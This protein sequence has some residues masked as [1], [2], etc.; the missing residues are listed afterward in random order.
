MKQAL[1]NSVDKR[2]LRLLVLASIAIL[3]I[4]SDLQAQNAIIGS[5]F[6]TG[7][8]VANITYP[9]SASA[10]TSRIATFAS[11][12]TGL[13]YFRL[14]RGWTGSGCFDGNNTEYGPSSNTDTQ[15]SS[16]GTVPSTG[17]SSGS[18]AWFVNDNGGTGRNYIIKTFSPCNSIRWTMFYVQGA[19][20]TISSV[21]RDKSTIYP[22]QTIT[23]TAGMSAALSTGQ[24]VYC[25]YT[26]DNYA[27]STVAQM[28]L[29][30]G[31]NY[32]V[33]TPAFV[34][35]A[36]L[37][38]YCFTS[39]SGL[40]IS[41]SDADFFTINLN[42]NGGSN[43][44]TTVASAWVT[45]GAGSSNT[46][47]TWAGGVVPIT[48]QPVQIS[49]A[50]TLNADMTVSGL[51]I[52]GGG[53][54][55][56][57]SNTININAGGALVN[58][59]TFNPG[60]G[61]VNFVGA[62][63]V[64]GSAGCT[65]N[66]LTLNTGQLTL[67]TAPTVNGTFTINSGNLDNAAN[68]I[69]YGASST[70]LY[71]AA[72]GYTIFKEWNATADGAAGSG[73]P[74]N[75]SVANGGTL[76]MPSSLESR[77][78]AGSLTLCATC[79]LTF[80]SAGDLILRGS[81]TNNHT[82]SNVNFGSG[83]GRAVFFTVPSGT[84][85]ISKASG[86]QTFPFLIFNNAGTVNIASPVEVTATT[87][88]PLQIN[89][90]GPI[91][92]S[93][94]LTL[95]GDNG[96]IQAN[97]TSEIS[98][99]STQSIFLTGNKTIPSSNTGTLSIG[100]N[101]VLSVANT[102]TLTQADNLSILSGGTLT[103]TGTLSSS[104]T[105]NLAS[106]STTNANGTVAL[107]T[108]SS[109]T[110]AGRITFGS[111]SLLRYDN[112]LTIGNEWLATTDGAAGSGRPADVSVENSGT[113]TMPTSL[114][115][116]AMAGS[117]TICATCS[118][119]FQ[120]SGGLILRGSWINNHAGSNVN[121]GSSRPVTFT[122]PSGTATI[123]KASGTQTF[124]ILILNNT[125][126]VNIACPV[127][128]STAVVPLQIN[129]SG[130]ITLGNSLTLINDGGNIQVNGTSEISASSPQTIFING[131]KIIPSTNTGTL[132]I[133][134]NVTLAI[135]STKS[136]TQGDI[137]SIM[138][139]ATLSVMGTMSLTSFSLTTINGTVAL[140]TGASISGLGNFTYGSSSILRYDNSL[141]V[142]N[143]WT[144]TS[145]T[146]AGL[147]LPATV[148]IAAGATLTVNGST[149]VA[150]LLSIN[151]TGALTFSSGHGINLYTGWTN[152]HATGS[153]ITYFSDANRITFVGTTAAINS[154]ASTATFRELA[155]NTTGQVTT[156]AN[157]VLT[158]TTTPLSIVNTG[159]LNLS[160]FSITF[161]GT[162]GDLVA[163][164]SGAITSS[165]GTSTITI[166][167][168]KS[169]PASNT[170]TL[171]FGTGTAP[172]ISTGVTL[173]QNDNISLVSGVTLVVTG[174]LASNA[175]TFTINSG[176]AT[177]V[178]GAL[179]MGGGVFVGTPTY[180][181]AAT[182]TYTATA[183]VSD[184]WTATSGTAAGLGL[185]ATVNISGGTATLAAATR[186]TGAFTIASA[187]LVTF[188][189][190]SNLDLYGSFNNQK[191]TA[192]S[193]TTFNGN[194]TIRFVG[195]S[196]TISVAGGPSGTQQFPVLA[197]N[198]TGKVT[199]N[200]N[201]N[202]TG[203]STNAFLLASTGTV[204]IGSYT[205]SL[206]GASPRIG[207]TGS[208]S[209][210]A[211]SGQ[212]PIFS[213][214][215]SDGNAELPSSNTAT[216]TLPS[217]F[218]L[219]VA[220]GTLTVNAAMTSLT[221]SAINV[222]G[223]LVVGS[224]GTVTVNSGSTMTVNGAGTLDARA[225]SY[226]LAGSLSNSG[227][228][229][230]N[231]SNFAVT[232][233][234][235]YSHLRNGGALPQPTT[236]TSGS[237]VN[238]NGVTST[239]PTNLNQ[240]F[241]RL[242]WEC[243]GQSV[244]LEL[245]SN[246]PANSTADFRVTNTNNSYLGLGAS[247][248]YTAVTVSGKFAL[249]L[250]G[251]ATNVTLTTPTLGFVNATNNK[252]QLALGLNPSSTNAVLS[253]GTIQFNTSQAT[254][255]AAL[256]GHV[257]L[258]GGYGTEQ[259][260]VTSSFQQTGAGIGDLYCASPSANTQ[261]RLN[262]SNGSISNVNPGFVNFGGKVVIPVSSVYTFAS[263]M[264]GAC[265][266]EVNG[267]TTFNIASRVL[268][269]TGSFTLASGATLV[270]PSAAGLAA[271]GATGPIR[272]TGTRSYSTGATYQY[273]AASGV[274]GA[275]LPSTVA[276]LFV[277]SS[278]GLTL[279][280]PV[281]VST[282]LQLSTGSSLTLNGQTLR[283]S[284]TSTV[285]V[286]SGA[287]IVPSTTSRLVMGS[288]GLS[289][290][291][292]GLLSSANLGTLEIDRTGT[293]SLGANNLTL[294]QG[295]LLTNGSLTIPN[296]NELT[297]TSSATWPTE[298]ATKF[299]EGKTIME[300]RVV[301]TGSLNFMGLGLA[302]GADD[303]GSIS[304]VRISGVNGRIT[305]NGNSGIN[306][307]WD[308]NAENQPVSGRDVTF[309]WVSDWDNGRNTSQMKFWR[310]ISP[311]DPWVAM[312]SLQNVGSTNPRL[313]TVNTTH[314]SEWTATDNSG[315]LPVVFSQVIV[316]RTGTKIAA[317]TF[318]AEDERNVA[319]YSLERSSNGS[320]FVPVLGQ[321]ASIIA[322]GT[323][324][325]TYTV[326]D[327]N[328]D[329]ASSWYYRI[330][331][332]DHDGATDISPAAL[333]RADGLVRTASPISAVYPNPFVRQLSLD[334]NTEVAGVAQIS[335]VGTDGRVAYSTSQMV[336]VGSQTVLI[337]DAA[338][339][340]LP[341]GIYHLRCSMPDGSQQSV[342]VTK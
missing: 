207:L 9:F 39:G 107:A 150:G 216:L 17:T 320:V 336:A 248:T 16:F 294:H 148:N 119:T 252:A 44:T 104:G 290:L 126:T 13:R 319:S 235:T 323:S 255:D 124:A 308:V 211:T 312:G 116:R 4:F 70:L 326:Q 230:T 304:I 337:V 143:E 254:L 105:L 206:T 231:P 122:V 192:G 1:R 41:P 101:V 28:A 328:S 34:A 191:A 197:F 288:T 156:N 93:N 237:I 313:L 316:R 275:G 18:G 269:N 33:T 72:G 162:G 249:N 138:S 88:S 173:T 73:R 160:G 145:G 246:A 222:T 132:N 302:A 181:S 243:S 178:N 79:S 94:S 204:E 155:I 60:G 250:A 209:I 253:V 226:S 305:S 270:V 134:N 335:L 274:T 120:A 63:S 40:T 233:A 339:G 329:A 89:N 180:G 151:A 225:G 164:G 210:T 19:V 133:G 283:F 189:S 341:K 92:L 183:T 14:V 342:K 55:T 194:N 121:F 53:S 165:A 168:N 293:F 174:T 71:N 11:N 117:L 315:P 258:F 130:P 114:E 129:G 307:N 330:R 236:W 158:S 106:G 36:N 282:A 24:S 205:I 267:G 256:N 251:G 187:A 300:P 208:G 184:E 297:F 261:I 131:N 128:V 81:W 295:L 12:N 26:T 115:T 215:P 29:V 245:G 217:S 54:L 278:I 276:T 167:G 193:N 286:G 299:V 68:N 77:A 86:T 332:I 3:A 98:A 66:N 65:F 100:N 8:S 61:T 83:N 90:S 273:T 50:L 221:S 110:G 22:G 85:T 6:S 196:N 220:S 137:L 314:F 142:G 327:H 272:S 303:L 201:V 212:S 96:N 190:G 31:S 284:G 179:Q 52:N 43:Y 10:G 277:A 80:Q 91:T 20:Q 170:G 109:V 260:E 287:T 185:P 280:N 163:N 69:T 310:R 112:S 47:A 84:A 239:V 2:A 281:A 214:A 298:T 95:S 99:S 317:I 257:V 259:L 176:A 166:A 38:Y 56:T 161:N 153:N 172:T 263:D 218:T 27:T 42:N 78:M 139:G 87:A 234:A 82:G 141:T 102:K 157:L 188:Q 144:A 232:A 285:S 266:I 306:C 238:I 136:L 240:V 186:A 219:Q 228:V 338:L 58:N 279:S 247:R 309:S 140:A 75:V 37:S 318:R 146:A 15:I 195:S 325:N 97:G 21:T 229:L 296:G 5:G 159:N 76:T 262:S 292:T 45:A 64:S 333:L 32:A 242:V 334:L 23:I 108:G 268:S 125:G 7:W 223:S 202:L 321:F 154:T 147:G 265:D 35:G 49:H 113:L 271:T 224:T 244:D 111:S 199:I 152:Q 30:S 198:H 74:A 227:S 213:L 118:L 62:G 289:T 51:T 322:K 177:T 311:S 241:S 200:T 25:R 203:S 46:P 324:A 59:G 169:V 57:T 103:I 135:A 149:R 127:Q 175:G 301:G 171:A 123:S 264:T 340:Q 48:G 182:L 331:S 291:P 67:T